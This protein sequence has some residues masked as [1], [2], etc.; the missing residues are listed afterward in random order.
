MQHIIVLGTSEPQDFQ[1]LDDGAALVGTGFDVGLEVRATGLTTEQLTAFNA[2]VVTWLSQAAG[3]VRVTGIEDLPLG[4]YYPRYTLTDSGGN[5][6]YAPNGSG[7]DEW[8]V[9]RV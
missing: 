1:I 7:A 6:G 8:R 2:L 4:T 9:V 3:T 5:V